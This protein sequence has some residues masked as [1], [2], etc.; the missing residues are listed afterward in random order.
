MALH[1]ANFGYSEDSGVPQEPVQDLV[2]LEVLAVGLEVLLR[3]LLQVVL[4]VE[5]AVGC[6][7]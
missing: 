5:V 6:S 3:P 4:D 7:G 1:L 2:A